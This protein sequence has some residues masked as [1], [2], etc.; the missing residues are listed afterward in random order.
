MNEFYSEP[1]KHLVNHIL[2]H[3]PEALTDIHN[4]I[5]ASEKISKAKKYAWMAVRETKDPYGKNVY[6]SVASKL[7]FLAKERT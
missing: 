5:T 6:G 4:S 1:I 7:Y 2:K 3:H